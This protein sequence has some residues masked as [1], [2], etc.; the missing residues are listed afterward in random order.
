MVEDFAELRGITKDNR[1]I[2]NWEYTGEYETNSKG[3]MKK[4][5]WK[6]DCGKTAYC[7]RNNKIGA[8]FKR[9]YSQ[10]VPVGQRFLTNCPYCG[11]ELNLVNPYDDG[12]TWRKTI[13][14]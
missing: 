7:T 4:T 9:Y 10:H 6:T 12:E 11:N 5:E 2:C 1:G 14:I 3:Y 13:N 8:V